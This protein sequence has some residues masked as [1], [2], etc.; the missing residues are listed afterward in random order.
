MDSERTGHFLWHSP[1]ARVHGLQYEVSSRQRNLGDHIEQV[2]TEPAWTAALLPDIPKY[3]WQHSAHVGK[4][5]DIGD[6]ELLGSQ[7]E[8]LA[9][10]VVGGTV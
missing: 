1:E 10:Q 4:S 9:G 3:P 2:G 6:G 7:I 5:R 8:P